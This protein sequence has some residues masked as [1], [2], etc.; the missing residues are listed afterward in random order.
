MEKLTKKERKINWM[1][2]T[3]SLALAVLIFVSGI[4]IG[5]LITEGKASDIANIE[6]QAR[7]EL[8][9]IIVESMIL[10]ENPCIDPSM[11]SEK[12]DDLGTKLTYLEAEYSKSDPRILELKEPY[13]LLEV[14]HYLEMKKMI[15]ECNYNYTLVLFF[16]S[17]SQE[18]EGISEEQGFVLDYLRKKFGNVKVY[19]F[20][21]DLDIGIIETLKK[22]ND[23]TVIPSTIIEGKV[24]AG[25][26]D[27]EEL[28]KVLE[29]RFQ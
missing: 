13:T 16:Y 7:M 6:K 17:N 1:K 15:E 20:D 28:E 14:R 12:L 25:F 18:N 19:S 27:K 8:E 24:Y 11:L 26:H 10:E 2:I 23:I 9:N 29:G 3:A 21:A 5:N 22:V 4:Y